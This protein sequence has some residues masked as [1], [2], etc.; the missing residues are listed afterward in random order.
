M[1]GTMHRLG[2]SFLRI[3]FVLFLYSCFI[4]LFELLLLGIR[5]NLILINLIIGLN[6]GFQRFT[7]AFIF[8]Y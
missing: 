2:N 1:Q 3:Q 6:D 4:S 7:K 5:N 8:L